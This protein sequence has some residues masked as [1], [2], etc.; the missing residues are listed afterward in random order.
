MPVLIG[1]PKSASG[2]FWATTASGLNGLLEAILRRSFN[3][4]YK[5]QSD[6]RIGLYFKILAR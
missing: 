4:Y 3:V 2:L 6:F 5:A 1:L